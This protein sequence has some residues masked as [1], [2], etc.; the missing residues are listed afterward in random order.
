[1]LLGPRNGDDG[2]SGEENPYTYNYNL[3]VFT[4]NEFNKTFSGY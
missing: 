2:T 3:K 1:M 4:S